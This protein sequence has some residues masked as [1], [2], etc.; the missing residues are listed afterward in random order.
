MHVR[1][2]AMIALECF[3]ARMR[4][5]VATKDV[6]GF[7][8]AAAS[9]AIEFDTDMVIKMLFEAYFGYKCTAADVAFVDRFGWCVQRWQVLQW[10]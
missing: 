7:E 8:V 1:L 6:D 10:W 2:V 9:V 5:H 3:V 4:V